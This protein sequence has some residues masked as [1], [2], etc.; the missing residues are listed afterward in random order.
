MKS[1]FIINFQLQ[2]KTHFYVYIF[3]LEIRIKIVDSA[4]ASLLFTLIFVSI[5]FLR[6]FLLG[7]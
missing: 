2:I 6:R 1:S 7:L 3:K 5:H 4:I